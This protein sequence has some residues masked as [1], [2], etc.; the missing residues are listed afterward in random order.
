MATTTRR[1]RRASGRKERRRPA[2]TSIFRGATG[3]RFGSTRWEPARG[4]WCAP[5]F[6]P[7]ARSSR[8]AS[9]PSP[10]PTSASSGS[11]RTAGPWRIARR[12]FCPGRRC[13]RGVEPSRARG[14]WPRTAGCTRSTRREPT[15]C[16]PTPWER[17]PATSTGPSCAGPTGAA[18]TAGRSRRGCSDRWGCCRRTTKRATKAAPTTTTNKPPPRRPPRRRRTFFP[19]DRESRWR[20]WSRHR[21]RPIGTIGRSGTRSNSEKP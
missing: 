1:R 8:T 7:T 19:R 15:R 6:A 18:W 3:V 17:V 4:R 11:P 12:R 20:S 2:R 21:P 9:G 5:A 14:S 13:R 16:G 10:D